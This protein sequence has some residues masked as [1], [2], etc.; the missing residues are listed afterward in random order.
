MLFFNIKWLLTLRLPFDYY[1]C[2]LKKKKSK[3][4]TLVE[5]IFRK[6]ESV[7]FCQR[8][9]RGNQGFDHRSRGHKSSYR[10]MYSVKKSC[11]KKK[12]KKKT[13]N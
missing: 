10:C 1:S 8:C 3:K 9:F 4:A 6:F 5:E 2:Y 11:H 13:P 7:T 12:K